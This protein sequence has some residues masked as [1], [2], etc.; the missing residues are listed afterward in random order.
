M[1]SLASVTVRE[2][3]PQIR[4]KLACATAAPVVRRAIA[5]ALCVGPILIAINHGD[6]IVSGDISL[7]RVLKVALTMCVPYAV[8]TFS[9]VQ[10][11]T[12]R[13][14]SNQTIART[15]H[16]QAGGIE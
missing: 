8:S 5:S 10:A 9:S 16:P 15:A 4:Q 7:G 13:L 2:K 12:S 6:A 1:P 3:V 11:L 14:P